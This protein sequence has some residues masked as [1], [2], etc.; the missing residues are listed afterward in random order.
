MAEI[1]REVRAG[2]FAHELEVEEA[3][4]YARLESARARA[5]KTPLEQVFRKLSDEN[6]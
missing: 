4:G 3:S 1:L 2:R 5:R 6:Q